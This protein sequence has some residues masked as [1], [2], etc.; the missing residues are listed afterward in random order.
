MPQSFEPS[1]TTLTNSFFTIPNKNLRQEVS[2]LPKRILEHSQKKKWTRKE[3]KAINARLAS[4]PHKPV[5]E[6]M[7]MPN[8]VSPTSLNSDL[9]F[10]HLFVFHH[11]PTHPAG[12]FNANGTSLFRSLFSCIFIHFLKL[13]V[14]ET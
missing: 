12:F 2:C 9:H 8:L 11:I 13:I 3:V 4:K 5:H 14:K 7:L 6:S 10:F 1:E